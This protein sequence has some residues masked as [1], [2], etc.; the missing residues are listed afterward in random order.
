MAYSEKIVQRNELEAFCVE[1]MLKAGMDEEQARITAEVLVTNDRLGVTTHGSKQLRLLLNSMRNGGLNAQAT[2]EVV[3]EGPGWAMIDGHYT[4]PMV[5]A[6]QAMKTAISKAKVTGISYVGVKNSSHFAAAGYYAN[7]AAK[8]DMIGLSMSNVDA[9][10]AIPGTKSEVIGTNPIGY[11]VP[12]GEEKPV[13]LDIATSV[14]AISKVYAAKALGKKIPEN[15]LIDGEGKMTTDPSKYPDEG[16]ILPM[17][18][19]KGYGIAVLIEVL[20]GILTGAAFTKGVKRWL[21]EFKD[22]VN[23]GHAFIAINVGA[24]MPIEQFQERMDTMIREIRR[25]PKAKGADRIYLPGEIEW[26]HEAK[27][28][29]EGISL[30]GDSVERL[31]GMAEDWKLDITKL[32]K[33]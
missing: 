6:C 8:E 33:E 11:A 4:M 7:L 2:P 12:A 17:A 18:G 16:A 15:W 13:F 1:A 14:T 27:T 10:M 28:Q 21:T 9:C 5:T 32:F 24:M 22:P 26:D 19:H 25:A 20:A 23:Q 30:P 29:K 31:V 3:S